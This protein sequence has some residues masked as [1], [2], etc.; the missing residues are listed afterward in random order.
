MV[1]N[2]LVSPSSLDL[3]MK[4]PTNLP[5]LKL[6][7]FSGILNV[8]YSVRDNPGHIAGMAYLGKEPQW[9]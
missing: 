4:S 5:I 8:K 2:H 9:G 6:S 3:M 7:V 1:L